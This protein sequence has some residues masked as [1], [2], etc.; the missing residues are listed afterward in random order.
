MPERSEGETQHSTTE[1]AFYDEKTT[2]VGFPASAA[3]DARAL[4]P[5]GPTFFRIA[6]CVTGDSRPPG[7]LLLHHRHRVPAPYVPGC[8]HRCNLRA[9]SRRG[10]VAPSVRG[11]CVRHSARSPAHP[12]DTPPTAM[13]ISRHDGV[14]SRPRS[15]APT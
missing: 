13:L 9:D 1:I 8:H 15:P 5:F 4:F 12:L 11:R 6:T 10:S 3:C 7:H 14:S 2:R